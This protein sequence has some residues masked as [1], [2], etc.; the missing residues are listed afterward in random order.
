MGRKLKV[1]GK[2]AI[3]SGVAHLSFIEKGHVVL[4]SEYTDLLIR[5]GLGYL[6]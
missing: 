1:S 3:V 5:F 2:C 4:K 6:E